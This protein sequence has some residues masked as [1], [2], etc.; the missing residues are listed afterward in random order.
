MSTARTVSPTRAEILDALQ[1][2]DEARG[3]LL[4]ALKNL[5]DAPDLNL[6]SLEASTIRRMGQARAIIDKIEKG[7]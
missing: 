7:D 6:D 4:W 3:N 2:A 5:L 1:E